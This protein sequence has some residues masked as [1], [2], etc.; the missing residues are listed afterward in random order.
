MIRGFNS[1]CQQSP[2]VHS[3]PGTADLL[4]F[5]AAWCNWVLSHQALEEE[6]FFPEIDRLQGVMGSMQV[7]IGQQPCLSALFGTR[8]GIRHEHRSSTV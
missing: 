8:T 1:I 4:F 7:N 5:Y 2:S 6:V 3:P